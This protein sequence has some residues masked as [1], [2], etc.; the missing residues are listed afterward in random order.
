MNKWPER[1]SKARIAAATIAFLFSIASFIFAYTSWHDTWKCEPYFKGAQ[2]VIWCIW[3][4][5]P[6][7]YFIFEY[8]MFTNAY[9][10]I[11]DNKQT[12]LLFE[13][14]KTGQDIASKVWLA[15]ATVLLVLYF[16][17]DLGQAADTLT[18]SYRH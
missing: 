6:P 16:H 13:R 10:P 14:L 11:P 12:P 5:A 8:G 18:K 17:K 1:I 3:T 2:V 15:I 7:V 4:I 9:P